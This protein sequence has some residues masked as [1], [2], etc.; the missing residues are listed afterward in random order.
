MLYYSVASLALN[1]IPA[2]EPVGDLAILVKVLAGVM[3]LLLITTL[4][5]NLFF[6]SR[7]QRQEAALRE[8]V[9]KLKDRARKLE[10]RLRDE[11]EVS[12]EEA[13]K[14]LEQL[15]TGFVRLL[16]FIS[17]RIPDDFLKP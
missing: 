1:G 4:F 11:Y 13:L 3:G 10:A 15:G 9:V 14:W 12:T 17:S 16:T 8:A 7:Q 5:V 2:V 6:S